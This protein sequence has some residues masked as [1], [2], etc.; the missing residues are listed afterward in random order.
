MPIHENKPRSMRKLE[1]VIPVALGVIVV[2]IVVAVA[3]PS[4]HEPPSL[5]KQ[6]AKVATTLVLCLLPS[7]WAAY[8][9]FWKRNSAARVVA[10]V[11]LLPA[12]LWL[13]YGIHLLVRF[14]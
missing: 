6:G 13:I 10:I 9:L 3:C 2:N 8:L 5:K 1:E 12:I 4:W 11:S 14:L 7:L